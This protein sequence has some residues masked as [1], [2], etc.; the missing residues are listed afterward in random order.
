M[1]KIE[2][3]KVEKVDEELLKEIVRRI[4]EVVA[5][6]EIILFG[7]WVY[8]KPRKGSDLDILV[9]VED[10]TKSRYDMMVKLYGALRGILISKDIVVATSSQVEEWKNV[11]QAFITKIVKKGRVIYERKD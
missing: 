6:L 4:T 10:N 7:S 2:L 1:S 9:I 8:G 5:P 11:P 3:I